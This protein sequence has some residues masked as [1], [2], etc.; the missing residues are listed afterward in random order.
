M[1]TFSPEVPYSEAL[2]VGDEQKR[3]MDKIMRLPDIEKDWN[4]QYVMD[5]LHELATETFG[6]RP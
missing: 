2:R 1:V 5:Q 6:E 3:V 4:E